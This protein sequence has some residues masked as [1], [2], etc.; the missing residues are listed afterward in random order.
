MKRISDVND[1][2]IAVLLFYQ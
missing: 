1:I 2:T